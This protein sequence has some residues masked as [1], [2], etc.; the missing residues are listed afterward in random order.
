MWLFLAALT[1]LFLASLVAY[2]LIRARRGEAGTV[3][4]PAG[5]WLSTAL[6]L[7]GSV[8]VHLALRAV[9]RE[10]QGRFRQMLVASLVLACGFV[11]VQVPS[12]GVLLARHRPGAGAAYGLMFFL[13]LVHAMHVVGGIV[14]LAVVTGKALRQRYDHEA[15]EPVR[16]LA[17]YWHFLDGVWVVMFGVLLL[18]R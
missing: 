7:A 2:G 16:W 10:K 4:I 11:A 1:V 17:M 9:R 8:S 12:M 6:I 3:E 15:H 5:L 18:T 14:P 13:I